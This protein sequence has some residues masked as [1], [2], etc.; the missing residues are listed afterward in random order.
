M[1]QA[2]R[3]NRNL[4]ILFLIALLIA[5]LPW[6]VLAQ[7]KEIKK[8]K[9]N[10]DKKMEDAIGYAQAVRVGNTIYVSGAVGWGSMPD[11]F[12]NVYSE[13][14]QSLKAYGASFK[15]V[16]KENVFTTDLDAFKKL[17]GHRIEIYA[18]DFPAATWVQVERLYSPELILEI[19]LIAELPQGK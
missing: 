4:F 15:N 18:G 13:L 19:E 12:K 1:T 17:Q 2:Q 8:E 10:R 16:V 9:F 6:V 3:Q 5:L 14:E 7:D 11:A